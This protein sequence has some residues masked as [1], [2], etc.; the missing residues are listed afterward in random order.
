MGWSEST[1][2][3]QKE[4]KGVVCRVWL[5]ETRA[6]VGMCLSSK[7]CTHVSVPGVRTWDGTGGVGKLVAGAYNL[8]EDHGLYSSHAEKSL[9]E[10]T[11][12]S[13]LQRMCSGTFAENRWWGQAGVEATGHL[14]S[15]LKA[16]LSVRNKHG[17]H[18]PFESYR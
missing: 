11:I 17:P 13:L 18:I 12:P 10:K 7:N 4:V 2:S 6:L 5:R 15:F 8:R 9:R 16:V 3:N 14:G 1:N